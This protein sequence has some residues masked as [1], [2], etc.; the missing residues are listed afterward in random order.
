MSDKRVLI[1]DE[2]LVRKI[3]ENRGD[4]GRSEF[5]SVLI[6]TYL[7]AGK[8]EEEPKSHSAGADDYVTREEFQQFEQGIKQLMQNF[9]EFF[10]SYGLEL[11]KQPGDKTFKEL[12]HKLQGLGDSVK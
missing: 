11:G 9:L 4:Y 12:K 7:A 6:D 5:L 10:L 1:V 2:E 3:D 8:T